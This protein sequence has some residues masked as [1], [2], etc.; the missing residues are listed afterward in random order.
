MKIAFLSDPHIIWD[1]P[2][3]R[4]DDTRE[5]SLEKFEF[6]LDWCMD[7]SALLLISG[8]L[9]DKPRS[10]HMYKR[11]KELIKRYY[12]RICAVYG[13]HDMY[14]RSKE[15]TMLD[16]LNIEILTDD[17][18]SAGIDNTWL[19]GAS[20]GE[21]VPEVE[22]DGFNILVIHAPISDKALWKGHDYIN[23]KK[24]LKAFNEFD[25]IHCG[26]IHRSF[27]NISEDYKRCILNTGPMVRKEATEYNFKHRPCFYWYDAEEDTMN[28]VEIPHR[29]AEEVLSRDH[30][31]KQEEVSG[32]L[33]DFIES[34]NMPEEIET[35]FDD[36]LEKFLRENKIE[37]EVVDC[38]SEIMEEDV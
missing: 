15:A 20:Y 10:W 33:D 34:V 30:I 29:P 6:V 22:T 16:L 26:D 4:L 14:L 12:V 5:T 37:K 35:N 38:L 11:L 28:K 25:I 8:D 17:C 7:N 1:K 18:V 24:F 13:Q 21:E 2:I 23:S 19:Y 9:T 31:E 3:A 27:L 32:M 36:N